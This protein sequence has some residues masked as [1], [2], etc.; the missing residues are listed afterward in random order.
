MH[1]GAALFSNIGDM[2]TT[3]TNHC[4][5][6]ISHD[7]TCDLDLETPFFIHPER[8]RGRIWSTGT[9]PTSTS[10]TV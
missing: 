7:H 2:F 9:T 5:S 6:K 10:W 4:A 1:K 3:A 8:A